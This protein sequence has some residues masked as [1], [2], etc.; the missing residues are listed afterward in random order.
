MTDIPDW[1][2]ICAFITGLIL[3]VIGA[4]QMDDPHA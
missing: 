2:P 3:G 4:R 1:Y